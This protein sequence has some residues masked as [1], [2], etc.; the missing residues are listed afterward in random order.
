MIL[1]GGVAALLGGSW[2]VGQRAADCLVVSILR[3]FRVL[4]GVGGWGG[5]GGVG[6]AGAGQRGKWGRGGGQGGW[7]GDKTSFILHTC[8]KHW[9]LQRFRLF[10]QRI[11]QGCGT[12]KS[13]TSMPFVTMPKTLVFAAF[14]VQSTGIYCALSLY[15]VLRKYV[16][17]A[18]LALKI[19]CCPKKNSFSKTPNH[20]VPKGIVFGTP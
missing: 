1:E 9:Y 17:S 5:G 10:V 6:Q 8:P 14:Y 3:F 4:L 7:G 16:T 15:N 2:V 19:P 11:A 18:Y 13:V 12:R 20:A